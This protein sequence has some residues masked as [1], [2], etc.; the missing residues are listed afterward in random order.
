MDLFADKRDRPVL[1]LE[2]TGLERALIVL[3]WMAAALSVGVVLYYWPRL[4]AEV[5]QHFNSRGEVNGWGSRGLVPF[6]PALSLVLVAGLTWLM[7]Y[8]HLYNYL[9]P[10]TEENARR[11]Y[12]LA[13]QMLAAITAVTSF[14]FAMLSWGICRIAV[15]E[16][17]SMAPYL[18]PVMMVLLFGSIGVYFARAHRER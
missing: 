16:S 13:N 6:L 8:P 3:A 15:G 4:P 17:E 1:D 2:P 14:M 12:Q 7:R 11:Q 9:W 10:I 5:P 18:M